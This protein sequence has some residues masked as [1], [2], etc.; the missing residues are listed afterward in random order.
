MINKDFTSEF[1]RMW[2]KIT[3]KSPM[4]FSRYADGE[5]ALMQGRKIDHSSQAFNVDRWDSLNDGITLIGKDLKETLYHTDPEWYYA[6][7]CRCCDPSG[8]EWLLKEIKQPNKNITYSNLWINDNYKHFIAQFGNIKE[9]VYLIANKRGVNGMYP[10][11]VSGFYAIDDN[12]VKYWADNKLKIIE[13]MTSIAKVFTG[14]LYL[15]S[16]GPLSEILI[17]YLWQANPTNRYIDVGSAIDEF[18]HLHK[19][20]PFMMEGTPYFSKKC[21]F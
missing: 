18:V 8:Q 20:R 7:S 1:Y 2:E 11:D 6:I 14:M 12:C 17:H 4:C 13:N 15:I 10:W 9:P 19:T 5:V 16:A 3:S 21:E